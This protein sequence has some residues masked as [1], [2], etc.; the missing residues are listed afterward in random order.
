MSGIAQ[1]HEVTSAQPLLEPALTKLFIGH[2]QILPEAVGVGILCSKSNTERGE[3]FFI[4]D[5]FKIAHP[6]EI[7]ATPEGVRRQGNAA[8]SI[9]FG[10]IV[11]GGSTAARSRNALSVAR[12]QRAK[13]SRG[14]DASTRSNPKGTSRVKSI[15]SKW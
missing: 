11:E 12:H 8:K 9:R 4:N 1:L 2:C 5:A 3:E 15:L 14:G 13:S 7:S 10:D 6:T